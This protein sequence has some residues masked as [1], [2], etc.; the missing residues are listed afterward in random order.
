MEGH[1]T[2]YGL[3]LKARPDTLA[4]A[5]FEKWIDIGLANDRENRPGVNIADGIYFMSRLEG[6]E[7]INDLERQM[8]YAIKKNKEEREQTQMANIQAQSEEI[9]KQEQAKHQGELEKINADGQISIQEELIRGQIKNKQSQLEANVEFLRY[10]RE[11]ADA[12][13]GINVGGRK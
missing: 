2:Q 9:M 4:K 11:A 1:G 7:D 3:T 13:A 6:G 5:R 10:L 8:R 12:E